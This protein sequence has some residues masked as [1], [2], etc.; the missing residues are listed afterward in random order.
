MKWFTLLSL[1]A[2]T[3]AATAQPQDASPDAEA[4]VALEEG[5]KAP[6]AGMLFPT[7]TAVRWRQRIELL[8]ERLRIEVSA[9]EATAAI[10][11]RLAEDTLRV[12]EEQYRRDVATLRTS[13]LEAT[14][15]SWYEHPVLWL[16]FGVLISGLAAGLI[17]WGM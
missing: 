17:A 9:C 6:F 15:R 8:T 13:Y 7:A 12:R 11:L 2:I 5:D 10:R 4:I 3:S 14:R 16:T 1:L